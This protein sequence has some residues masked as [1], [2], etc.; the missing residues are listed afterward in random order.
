MPNDGELEER[1]T[2]QLPVTAPAG[3][4]PSRRVGCSKR[5]PARVD[6]DRA[7]DRQTRRAVAAGDG[8]GEGEG[9]EREV[10]THGWL[11]GGNGGPTARLVPGPTLVRFLEDS[12][13]A[14]TQRP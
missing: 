11:L 9:G 10:A 3:A 14:A 6:G 13:F 8:E 1:M 4:A 7:P 12:A 5:C 2:E